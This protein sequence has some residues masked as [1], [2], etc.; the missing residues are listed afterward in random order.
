MRIAIV[1]CG[2]V[3][4]LYMK[5][6]RLH[7]QLELVGV[8]DRE[9]S[10]CDRFCRFH[11]TR[12]YRSLQ[13]L[14]A[15]PRVELI[16]NLTN[17]SSHFEISK[18]AL[19]A[20]KH[21]YSEKPL[22]MQMNEATELVEL[23][24]TRGLLLSSAPCSY[25]SETAQ[26]MGKA[27]RAGKVGRVRLVYAEMDDGLVHRMPYRHWLS[28]SGVPWPY[29]DEFQVGC[30]LE[31][32]GYCLTWLCGWFGPARTVTTFASVQVPDKVPGEIPP[33][34]MAP[35]FSVAC[36]EFGDGVVA[37]LTCSIIAPHDHQMR[38]FGDDGVMWTADTWKYRSPVYLRRFLTI[39]RRMLLNPVRTKVNL[40][41][42]K[43]P[44]PKSSGAAEMDFCRGIA[45]LVNAATAN[46]TPRLSARFCLHVNELALAIH[47]AN[48]EPGAQK[49]LTTTFDP[50]PLESWA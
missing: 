45:D 25:L 35:D 16:V 11:G 10:R 2:F 19:L 23:A 43:L 13:E 18:A 27:L 41:D 42:S 21:V 14:L 46:R 24:E 12:A 15:D 38:I 8:Y 4:D 1:G 47:Y 5:T 48:V 9:L 22:A 39:R 7:P 26:T 3:A 30:T 31:H 40:P 36:I 17:P 37:R 33:E 44:Q 20:G 6:L 28:D 29:V 49:K 32:A 34:R 50:L